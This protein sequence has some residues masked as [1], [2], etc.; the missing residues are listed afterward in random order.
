MKV[1]PVLD[2]LDGKV[3]HGIAGER[4][5]YQPIAHSVITS[6]AEP[7]SVI[8]G[9]AEN[10][11]LTTFYIA[12]LNLIQKTSNKNCNEQ[13]LRMLAQQED[14]QLMVDGGVQTTEEALELYRW[15]V[16][17]VILGTETLQSLEVINQLVET[18]GKEK[19]IVSID[20]LD[21]KLLTQNDQLQGLSATK[22]LDI[23][24]PLALHAIIVLELR[25]VGRS[26]G[27]ISQTLLEILEPAPK[28]PIYAG[29]GVRTIEDVLELEKHGVSGCLIATA[30]HKGAIT[31]EDLAKLQ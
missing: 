26:S 31:R 11:G 14:Y 29:G 2:L 20:L 17:K 10:L 18:L 8:K 27:P 19:L 7:K 15:G 24:E 13:S 9:F 21:G 28:T 22:F 30:F 23:I 16:D 3:V 25:K 12:D 6:S 1:I 4:T 5:S